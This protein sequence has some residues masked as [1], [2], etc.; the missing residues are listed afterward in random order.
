VSK[1]AVSG[2]IT[3]IPNKVEHHVALLASI[4][5]QRGNSELIAAENGL[6][7]GGE[8]HSRGR[9]GQHEKWRMRKRMRHKVIGNCFSVDGP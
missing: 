9:I 7:S 3:C 2:L 8:V 6:D 4:G 5:V 1:N